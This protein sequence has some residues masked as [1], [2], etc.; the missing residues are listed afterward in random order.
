MTAIE[1]LIEMTEVS[2][3]AFGQAPRQG[4]QPAVSTCSPPG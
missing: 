3:L 4:R 1:T 2:Q